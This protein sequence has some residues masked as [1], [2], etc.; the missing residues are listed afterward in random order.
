MTFPTKSGRIEYSLTEEE[1]K[2]IVWLLKSEIQVQEMLLD[3]SDG[4]LLAQLI[5]LYES[6][7][8]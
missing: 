3:E 5:N 8:W 7:T 2:T 4:T 6:F 1:V